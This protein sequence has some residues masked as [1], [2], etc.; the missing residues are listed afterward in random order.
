MDISLVIPLLDEAES[1][2]ELSAWIEKVMKE[3]NYSYEV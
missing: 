2:P 1:L 3:H